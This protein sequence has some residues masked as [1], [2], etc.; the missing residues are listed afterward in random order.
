MQSQILTFHTLNDQRI[1]P[2]EGCVTALVSCDGRRSNSEHNFYI[3][4][5]EGCYSSESALGSVHDAGT[6]SPRTRRPLWAGSASRSSSPGLAWLLQT[7]NRDNDG[8]PLLHV[9]GTG[10][11]PRRRDFFTSDASSTLGRICLWLLLSMGLAPPARGSERH[12]LCD[13]MQPI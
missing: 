8:G 9:G 3:W 4:L 11:C 10:F 2:Y 6:V 1:A 13:V 12:F 5:A 7:S